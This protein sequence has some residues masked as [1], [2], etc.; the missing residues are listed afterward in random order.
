MH[1]FMLE[2]RWVSPDGTALHYLRRGRSYFV[3]S[4]L[5]QRLIAAGY[6]TRN[7]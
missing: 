7:D 4:M 2:S 5:A 6:A 1:I 3:E